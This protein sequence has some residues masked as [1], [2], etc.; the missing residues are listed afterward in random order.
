MPGH[1]QST[2][3][4]WQ[5]TV[6]SPA[7]PGTKFY[8]EEIAVQPPQLAWRKRGLTNKNFGFYLGEIF[9]R[10]SHLCFHNS[11]ETSP[12]ENEPCTLFVPFVRLASS[13]LCKLT[14][15]DGR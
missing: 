1:M 2:R 14:S 9:D 10:N 15:N 3:T 13:A 8:H 7:K 12:Y 5:K 4:N 6:G 11:M